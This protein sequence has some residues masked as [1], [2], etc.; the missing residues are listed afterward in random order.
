M[1]RNPQRTSDILVTVS[2]IMCLIV[3]SVVWLDREHLKGGYEVVRSD[4]VTVSD[5]VYER[6]TV[7]NTKHVP[8]LV[9]K[10]IIKDSSIVDRDS[11]VHPY[12]HSAYMD[13]IGLDRDTAVV[14]THISGIN[15]RLDSVSVTLLRNTPTITHSTVVTNQVE[16]RKTLKD[17]IHI[18]PNVSVGYG[19]LNRKADVYVGIGFGLEL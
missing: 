8:T 12:E 9:Y 18:V 2:L 16:R 4:T 17:R 15:A 6:D 13:T 5:T 1:T 7:T 3:F 14:K 11:V 19:L 10:T